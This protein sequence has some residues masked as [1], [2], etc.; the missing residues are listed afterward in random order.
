MD[1]KENHLGNQKFKHTTYG[2][3]IKTIQTP[4]NGKPIQ[5]SMKKNNFVEENKNKIDTTKTCPNK[6]PLNQMRLEKIF[7]LFKHD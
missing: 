7:P 4:Q 5:C 6:K 3:Q 2:L 1:S